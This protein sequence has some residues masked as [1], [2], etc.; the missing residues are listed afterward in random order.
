MLE[1]KWQKNEN[2]N[3][4]ATLVMS[5]LAYVAPDSLIDGIAVIHMK[6]RVG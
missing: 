4:C 5:N 2:Q 6:R 3:N 1:I